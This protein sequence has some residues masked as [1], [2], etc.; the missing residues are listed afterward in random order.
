MRINTKQIGIN[1]RRRATIRDNTHQYTMHNDARQYNDTQQRATR[2]NAQQYTSV[3]NNAR[4][5]ATTR[6]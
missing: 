5:R 3:R 2:N 6:D 1:T 4:Q